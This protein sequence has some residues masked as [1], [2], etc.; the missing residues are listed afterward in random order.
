MYNPRA[1]IKSPDPQNLPILALNPPL[2]SDSTAARPPLKKI[3]GALTLPRINSKGSSIKLMNSPNLAKCSAYL[4]KNLP[5]PLKCCFSCDLVDLDVSI[6][7][8]WL[9]SKL[10]IMNPIATPNPAD[11][12]VIRPILA[13]I[14]NADS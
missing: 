1:P 10:L 14:F 7:M 6:P 11:A 5:Y 12:T 4:F 2:V 9:N 8:F 3:A 13:T